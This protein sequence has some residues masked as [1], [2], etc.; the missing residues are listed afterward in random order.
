[1]KLDLLPQSPTGKTAKTFGA[2]YTDAAVAQFLVRWAVRSPY[3]TL[4]DPSFGGGVFLAAASEYIQ[5]LGGDPGQQIFGVELDEEVHGRTATALEAHFLLSKKNLIRSSFFDIE[6]QRLRLNA[7]VGNPPFIRYQRFTGAEREKAIRRAA[8]EGVTLRKLSSSWAAFV[9]H[10][11]AL[12]KLGGRLGLVLPAELGHAAY[13]QPVLEYLARSFERV[14]LLTFREKL[15]PRLSQDTLLLLAEGRRSEA[16]PDAVFELLDLHSAADLAALHPPPGVRVS[17][18]S[19]GDRPLPRAQIL[20][21]PALTS[22]QERLLEYWIPRVTRKL[23]QDLCDAPQTFHL[24][25]IAD[26]GIGYVTGNNH[27]FHL[28]PEQV[29]LWNIPPAFLKPAVRRGRA[30]RGLCFTP[31][32]WNVAVQKGEAGYLLHISPKAV[33]PLEVRRYLQ[34]GEAM[35]VPQAYKCRTRTPWYAVPHVY[36]PDAFLTYMSGETPRL[37]ANPAGVFA[38]NSLHTLRLRFP[39]P[40]QMERSLT[41]ASTP[42]GWSTKA[43]AVLWHTSLTQLSAEIV[44]HAMG[45]G[46]LKIEPGEAEKIILPKPNTDAQRLEAIADVLDDLVKKGQVEQAQRLADQLVLRDGL[47]LTEKEVEALS[48][49]SQYLSLRRQRKLPG[50]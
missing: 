3:D 1:M 41:D 5:Q 20:D 17:D 7:L 26:I 23:Y 40:L 18:C 28:S 21:T 10:A 44:G 30:L 27:F 36:Q 16:E 12:L 4:A 47:G 13:A 2:Y 9:V 22:G 24:G 11:A 31:S 32:D 29:E 43:L 8:A 19:N 45:G 33:L 15:F 48:R 6:P 37:V 49:A 35:G 34:R 46:M 14:S 42:R 39:A 38:P 50:L 25:E